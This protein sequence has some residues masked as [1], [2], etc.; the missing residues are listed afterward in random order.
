MVDKPVNY[1]TS[2]QKITVNPDDL[3]Q[4]ATV[5]LKTQAEDVGTTLSSIANT[6]N[7]LKLSW[8]GGSADEAKKFND[9]WLAVIDRLFGPADQNAELKP[10]EAV[11]G[12]IG[13][14]AAYAAANFGFA[15]DSV[16][17]SF[18]QFID[19]K[20]GAPDPNRN[21]TDGPITEINTDPPK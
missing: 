16:V 2:A 3:Y 4:L 1:N 13:G 6:W 21:E 15:E 19:A 10:G 11:L 17:S 14:A 9:D 12:R 5:T 20:P 18:K 7:N 8:Y